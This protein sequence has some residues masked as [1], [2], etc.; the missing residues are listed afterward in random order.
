ME[1]KGWAEPLLWWTLLFASMTVP[2][3]FVVWPRMW[4][5]QF[6]YAEFDSVPSSWPFGRMGW[7]A[8][9]RAW[10]VGTTLVPT[11][12]LWA[13][14]FAWP[15]YILAWSALAS[16]VGWSLLVL[17]VMLFNRPSFV[18]PPHLRAEPGLVAEITGRQQGR[19]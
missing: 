16:F 5:G 18:I 14:F 2:L 8:F 1:G 6:Q 19:S 12:V 3:V 15:S 10:F 11:T 13:F 17:A 9:V 4:R 7:H